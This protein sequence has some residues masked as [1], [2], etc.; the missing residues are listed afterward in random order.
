[1]WR[2]CGLPR[3]QHD[4]LLNEDTSPQVASSCMLFWDKWQSTAGTTQCYL[5]KIYSITVEMSCLGSEF[6]IYREASSKYIVEQS[7]SF[8][9]YIRCWLPPD[10][11]PTAA[12]TRFMSFWQQISTI[13]CPL[14]LSLL[15][16]QHYKSNQ[17]ESKIS[18]CYFDGGLK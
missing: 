15:P 8:C 4:T 17:V 3:I 13:C 5:H 10:W 11:L 7:S 1:M 2:S 18:W 14:I 6:N 12:K 16:L 9:R